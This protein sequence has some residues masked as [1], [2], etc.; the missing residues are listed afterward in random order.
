M[1]ACLT[2]RK[3]LVLWNHSD[4]ESFGASPVSPTI[5]NAPGEFVELFGGFVMWLFCGRLGT[6]LRGPKTCES[7]LSMLL[8]RA[9]ERP[10]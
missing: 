1:I 6:E 3:S 4:S 10:P 8:S 2:S 7:A 5:R 9:D